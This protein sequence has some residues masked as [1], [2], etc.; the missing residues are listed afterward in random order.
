M[1]KR[2]YHDFPEALP[3]RVQ[4]RLDLICSEWDLPPPANMQWSTVVRWCHE[5]KVSIDWLYRGLLRERWAMEQE[6][7]SRSKPPTACAV[8]SPPDPWDAA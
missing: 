8:A 4:A 1:S 2:P 5:H 7:R 6:R 3:S